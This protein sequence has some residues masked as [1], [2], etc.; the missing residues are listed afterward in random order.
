SVSYMTKPID[1]RELVTLL[2]ELEQ[3]E[4]NGKAEEHGVRLHFGLLVGET[5]E[6]LRVYDQIEKIA[7]TDN[8]VLLLGETGTGK[9]LA[10]EAIHHRSGRTGG[11]VAVNCG[12]LSRELAGSEL[13]GHEKGSFTGAVRHHS[14]FFQRADK[15]TLF[16]DEL[17]EMPVE[18]QPHF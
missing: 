15:G 10:A 4:L 17:T 12:S 11:Y 14:G 13:F 3:Q 16:L 18:L 6:M 7:V 2:H 1:S 9:E 8:P 5:P